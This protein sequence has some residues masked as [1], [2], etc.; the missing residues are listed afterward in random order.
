MIWSILIASHA[1]RVVELN[2]LA[3]ILAGQLTSDVEVV[4]LWNRGG[5]T[6]ADYREMLVA[7]AQGQWVSFVDDDDRVADTY[8]AD[9]VE[10]LG[11]GPDY[12]GF[13]VEVWDLS[14][15]IGQKGRKW[16]AVH[17]LSADRW[18]QKG[19]VFYRHVSH[20][21]PLRRELA[22]KAQWVGHYS[23][24]HRWADA[25]RPFVQTEVFIP[26][27]LYYY[28]FDHGRSIRGPSPDTGLVVRPELPEGFRFH[29]ESED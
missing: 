12:V 26:K 28:D 11:A 27:V 20:L 13:E 15:T 6:I 7:D 4:V 29:P 18:H 25:V 10:A 9:V 22:V 14:G 3:G 16:R 1:V 2:R 24:D 19:D 23:E 21:N 17:S 5:L 8:V